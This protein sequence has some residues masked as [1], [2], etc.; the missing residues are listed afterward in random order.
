L[1]ADFM[2]TLT[3]PRIA[4]SALVAY[5]HYAIRSTLLTLLGRR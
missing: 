2:T 4:V 3:A 1:D 5:V